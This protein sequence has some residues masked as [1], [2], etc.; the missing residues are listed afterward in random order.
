MEQVWAFEPDFENGV[1]TEALLQS[2]FVLRALRAPGDALLLHTTEV[3]KG[4]HATVFQSDVFI[5]VNEGKRGANIFLVVFGLGTDCEAD[6]DDL[7]QI[8]ITKFSKLKGLKRN[9]KTSLWDGDAPLAVA[10]GCA[11]N[12]KGERYNAI[13]AQAVVTDSS[14][15]YRYVL[16]NDLSN[17]MSGLPSAKTTAEIGLALVNVYSSLEDYAICECDGQPKNIAIGSERDKDSALQWHVSLAGFGGVSYAD[18]SDCPD[19]SVHFKAPG[20]ELEDESDIEKTIMSGAPYGVWTIGAL[21]YYIRT[22]RIPYLNPVKEDYPLEVCLRKK[23]AL[24]LETGF[25][26]YQKY[27]GSLSVCFDNEDDPALMRVIEMCT[28]GNPSE[29]PSFSL[30]TQLLTRIAWGSEKDAITKDSES[31]WMSEGKTPSLPRD[32]VN[33]S[34]YENRRLD[35]ED[36]RWTFQQR[37]IADTKLRLGVVALGKRAGRPGGYGSFYDADVGLDSDGFHCALGIKIY[38]DKYVSNDVE[39]AIAADRQAGYEFRCLTKLAELARNGSQQFSYCGRVPKVFARGVMSCH[40]SDCEFGC[41]A[42]LMEKVDG[43][44]LEILVKENKISPDALRLPNARET[45]EIGLAIAETY[46]AIHSFGVIHR[47]AQPRN[48]LVKQQEREGPARWLV[49]LIDFGNSVNKLGD[50]GLTNERFARYPFGA[51]EVFPSAWIDLETRRESPQDVWSIGAILYFVRTGQ[52]PYKSIINEYRHGS[53]SLSEA[54]SY[55]IAKK[56]CLS[57]RDGLKDSK[58]FDRRGFTNAEMEEGDAF[59]SD[60]IWDCTKYNPKSRPSAEEISRKLRVFLQLEKPS[61]LDELQ[62]EFLEIISDVFGHY[63]ASGHD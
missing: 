14:A 10:L 41:P 39:K 55:A 29:R 50:A 47:D 36:E 58:T 23:T 57:L 21:L 62:N 28:A 24:N 35:A 49:T 15:L 8:A 17:N 42:L 34:H 51:P 43:V 2:K 7:R 30:L 19:Y 11:K 63:N 37:E 38:G 13:A 40:G 26:E 52:L 22:S 33:K 5:P 46:A 6:S 44:E 1:V 59:L 54:E 20:L 53:S 31:F 56:N 32:E 16:R 60:L 45:A 12:E 3:G 48:I 4:R 27:N 18:C 25:A 61:R 9:G